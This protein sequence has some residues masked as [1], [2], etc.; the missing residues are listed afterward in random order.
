[1]QKGERKELVK[2]LR[3]V[4]IA[5]RPSLHVD[6]SA[7]GVRY[8]GTSNSVLKALGKNPV[9]LGCSFTLFFEIPGNSWKRKKNSDFALQAWNLNSPVGNLSLK[10]RP[11]VEDEGNLNSGDCCV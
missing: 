9:K 8:T 5:V 6:I 3:A 2:S 7:L 4:A 11:C 10:T 1:M